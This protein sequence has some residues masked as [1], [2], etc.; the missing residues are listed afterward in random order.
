MKSKFYLWV[1]V[2]VWRKIMFKNIENP[3]FILLK[4]YKEWSQNFICGFMFMPDKILCLKTENFS[5]WNIEK[6]KFYLWVYVYAWRKIMFKNI[7]IFSFKNI[8]KMKFYKVSKFY[9]VYISEHLAWQ[10]LLFLWKYWTGG[11]KMCVISFLLDS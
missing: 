7:E 2:Y 5:F 9:L 4:L 11:Y 8:E 6:M 1:Y 10:N 3:P